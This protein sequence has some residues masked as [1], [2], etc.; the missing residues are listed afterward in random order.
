MTTIPAAPSDTGEQRT[1]GPQPKL[2]D[3]IL[4]QAF[5]SEAAAP[6]AV[7]IRPGLRRLLP[8]DPGTVF[9]T[10]LRLVVDA[11]LP[12]APGFEIHRAPPSAP[13]AGCAP[14]GPERGPR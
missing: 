6:V 8:A 12:L 2:R 9:P 1:A 11:D 13:D 4:T 7:H 3:D 5:R 14:S 10:T